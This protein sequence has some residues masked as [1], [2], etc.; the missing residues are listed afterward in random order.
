[1]A[2]PDAVSVRR[3]ALVLNGNS[4][5][6]AF[7]TLRLLQAMAPRGDSELMPWPGMRR[8]MEDSNEEKTRVRMCG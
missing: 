5:D 1:M 8:K 3:M 2:M 7:A 6:G 4:G